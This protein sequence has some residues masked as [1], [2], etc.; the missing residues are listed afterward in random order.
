MPSYWEILSVGFSLASVWLARKVNIWAYPTG[1]IGVLIQAILC[2]WVWGLYADG[3]INVYFA[4]MSIWGWILWGNKTKKTAVHHWTV[5]EKRIS[6][7]VMVILSSV[8]YAVLSRYTNSTV[9][10][11][12]ALVSAASVSAMILMAKKAKE[13]WVWWMA[14]DIVSVPLYWYK[15]APFVA[16]QFLIFTLLAWDGYKKWKS[17]GAVTD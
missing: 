12:D 15:E 2:F 7:A 9:P 1:I 13:Q 16:F 14:I 5:I 17:M 3:C 6:V 4:I 8:F 10:L 11:A